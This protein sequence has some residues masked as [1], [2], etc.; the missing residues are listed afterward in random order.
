MNLSGNSKENNNVHCLVKQYKPFPPLKLH[1]GPTHMEFYFIIVLLFFRLNEKYRKA[2]P[3]YIEK[4][5]SEDWHSFSSWDH[6]LW[7]HKFLWSVVWI[8]DYGIGYAEPAHLIPD[9]RKPLSDVPL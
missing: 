1:I 4:A 8:W 2:F 5:L 3:A 7:S 9:Q 6:L